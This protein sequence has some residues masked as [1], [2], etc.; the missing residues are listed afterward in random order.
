[1][2]RWLRTILLLRKLYSRPTVPG[3][4]LLP[5]NY[6]YLGILVAVFLLPTAHFHRYDALA[7]LYVAMLLYLYGFVRAVAAR[8]IIERR[9]R[10]VRALPPMP[11]QLVSSFP[12]GTLDEQHNGVDSIRYIAQ[13]PDYLLY[14]TTFNFYA[15]TKMGDYLSKQ[16]FYTV[17]EVRL[18]RPVPHLI[19]DNIHAKGRQFRFRY[20]QTQQLSFE[21]N[22]DRQFTTY[23]P[24]H[25]EIDTLSFITPDVMQAMLAAKDYDIELRG[26]RLFL[27]GPLLDSAE[28]PVVL[29]LGQRIAQELSHNLSTYR[30][31]YIAGPQRRT[32]TLP[33]ARQ[34]LQS[35]VRAVFILAIS[36]VA[37]LDMTIFY[38]QLPLSLMRSSSR[39]WNEPLL[40][41]YMGIFGSLLRIYQITRNNR[42]A[43]K[44]FQQDILFQQAAKAGRR[45]L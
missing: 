45:S 36:V 19:F 40:F 14:D 25:Y 3:A 7:L 33:F 35:P 39:F 34:L 11:G 41:V 43:N 18:P 20:L 5:V 23:A 1:M 15:H 17:M 10:S 32:T 9:P 37:F 38:H 21:G 12:G 8:L 30:D 22:F 29:E 26:D 13:A 27:Y 42:R 28:I 24:E 31:S 2:I 4:L 6:A 44:A 16:L